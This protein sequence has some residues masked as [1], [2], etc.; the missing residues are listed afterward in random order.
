VPARSKSLYEEKTTGF[1]DASFVFE[2]A[3]AEKNNII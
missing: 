2:R 3:D 1:A